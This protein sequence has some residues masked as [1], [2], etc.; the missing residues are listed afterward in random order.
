[1]ASDLAVEV[2]GLRK[3]YGKVPVLDGVDL[4]IERGS[5]Y[6]LL[7]P[8][9]AGKT[10]TVR[11]LAT[12]ARA[13]AG[14]A[15]V[16]GFDVV[17]QRHVVRRKISLTGQNTAVDGAQ[18]GEENLRMMGRLAGLTRARARQRASVLLGQFDL[19]EAARRKAGTYSGG[20]RRRLDLAA[21]LM[22]N[23]EVIFLD[24]P[25]TGLDLRSRQAMWQV[26]RSLAD[27]GVTIFLTT[28][29]L[30]E[31]DQLASRVSVLDGGRIV[32]DGS[33]QALKQ[34]VGGQ[35]LDLVLASAMA[36]DEVG[37]LLGDRV[38]RRDRDGLTLGVATDGTAGHVRGLLDEVDPGRSA[39]RSFAVHGTSLDDVFLA[40]TGHP[41][42]TAVADTQPVTS[43]PTT[44]AQESTHV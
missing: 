4:S 17:S 20:M 2:T 22:G 29:Y 37:W 10:T 28:Q 21:S 7:G 13:D 41:A 27:S 6:S 15:R 3:A 40:L 26:I 24:E 8:N 31:A 44:S 19:A 30:E 12:L 33:P 25:T 18:T 36:F 1:M 5:V 43:A 11:I 23:P 32:A 39:V 9:G 16:A 34:Q 38:V 42:A 35:R 14:T